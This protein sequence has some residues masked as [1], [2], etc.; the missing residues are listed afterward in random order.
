[1]FFTTLSNRSM[2]RYEILPPGWSADYAFAVGW[3][4]PLGTYFA[5]VMDY[6]ISHD[7]DCVLVWVGAMPPYFTDLDAMMKVVNDRIRGRL[8]AIILNKEMKG[9]LIRDRR[10][11]D[12]TFSSEKPARTSKRREADLWQMTPHCPPKTM[13]ALDAVRQLYRDIQEW[14]ARAEM[15]PTN[16]QCWGA[17]QAKE[18]GHCYGG[19]YPLAQI[20][21]L[22]GPRDW[23]AGLMQGRSYGSDGTFRHD[24]KRF[25]LEPDRHMLSMMPLD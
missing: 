24:G 1:M 5:Q 23:P 10:K 9:R 7:D 22:T 25:Y 13:D 11:D 8:P 21:W 20:A 16:V 12:E 17:Q 19:R 4:R 2:S 6:S 18:K 14:V 15:D 3:D